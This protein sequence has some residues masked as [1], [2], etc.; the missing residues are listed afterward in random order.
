VISD[1]YIIRPPQ[2]TYEWEEVK[3]LLIDYRY[4]FR[5]GDCFTSFEEELNDI[6]HLYAQEGK[7]KLIA[8]SKD[9]GVMAGMAAF[10][11]LSPGVAEMKRLYV[12]PEYRGQHLGYALASSVL[13]EVTKR[14]FQRLVLDTMVEMKAAQELYQRLGFHVIEPYN[15]QDRVKVVCFEKKI[16]LK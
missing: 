14:G 16:G 3:R 6:E 12:V 4:E 10:R 15:H 8:V 9:N 1:K 7:R 5:D 2:T 13:E 11:T